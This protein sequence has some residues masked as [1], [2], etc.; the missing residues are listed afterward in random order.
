MK[1]FFK[2]VIY[3]VLLIIIGLTAIWGGS[4]FYSDTEIS[5]EILG[6]FAYGVCVIIFWGNKVRK[7]LDL[8]QDH[9]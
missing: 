9:E 1:R 2:K 3:V 7:I 6:Y 4:T 5:W 8:K